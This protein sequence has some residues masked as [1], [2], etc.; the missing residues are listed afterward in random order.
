MFHHS[1]DFAR[2]EALCAHGDNNVGDEEV[3]VDS[4]EG[5]GDGGNHHD[6]GDYNDNDVDDD[7]NDYG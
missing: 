1:H 3:K 7:H 4:I 2:L 6:G 5:G